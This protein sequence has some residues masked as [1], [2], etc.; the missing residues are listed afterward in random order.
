MYLWTIHSHEY[1]GTDSPYEISDLILELIMI[2]IPIPIPDPILIVISGPIPIPEIIPIT[3]SIVSIAA[4]D[5]KLY[6]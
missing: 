1:S 3:E 4:K 6:F 5:P 2:P